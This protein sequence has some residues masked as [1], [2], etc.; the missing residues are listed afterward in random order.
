MVEGCQPGESFWPVSFPGRSSVCFIY[1]DRKNR[2]L[3]GQAEA[4][5]KEARDAIKMHHQWRRDFSD[6]Y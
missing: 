2:D 3:G 6:I 4:S 5:L 1:Q